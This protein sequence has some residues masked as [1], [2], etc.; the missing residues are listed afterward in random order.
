[1][2]PRDS[3]ER[4]TQAPSQCSDSRPGFNGML[5]EPVQ[6]SQKD[7]RLDCPLDRGRSKNKFH[8]SR[9]HTHYNARVFDI[10]S[11]KPRPQS[12]PAGSFLL[13]RLMNVRYG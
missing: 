9:R 4:G 5:R 6:R 8:L 7:F 13:S 11:Y 3:P 12:E 1:M 2:I 10:L